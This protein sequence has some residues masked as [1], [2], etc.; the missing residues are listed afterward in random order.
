[1]TELLLLGL[2]VSSPIALPVLFW[3][4]TG[5]VPFPYRMVGGWLCGVA[6]PSFVGWSIFA[7]EGGGDDPDPWTFF[8]TVVGLSAFVS[9]IV[10]LVLQ[11]WSD[12]R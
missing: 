10:V 8:V 1:M 7:N 4:G 2:L 6:L 3:L 12:S 5:R 11:H 9:L